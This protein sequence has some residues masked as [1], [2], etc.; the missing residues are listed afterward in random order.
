MNLEHPEASQITDPVAFQRTLVEMPNPQIQK[1]LESIL[2]LAAP[3]IEGKPPATWPEKLLAKFMES[4]L[5]GI[6]L[7]EKQGNPERSS[8]RFIGLVYGLC[9]HLRDSEKPFGESSASTGEIATLRNMAV[10][11]LPIFAKG[12]FDHLS[13]KLE[14]AGEFWPGFAKSIQQVA[15]AKE[16]MIHPVSTTAIYFTMIYFRE[17]IQKLPSM[18]ALHKFLI[19]KLSEPMVGDQKRVEKVCKGIGLRF[20]SKGRPKK[21]RKT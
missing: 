2:Q 13:S 5:P 19:D 12:I 18:P 17:E 8:G 15:K 9:L 20:T 1:L 6:S 21:N 3:M 11:V 4:I 10:T 16:N 7:E 14:V